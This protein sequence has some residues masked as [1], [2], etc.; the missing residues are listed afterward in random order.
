[1]GWAIS[2]RSGTLYYYGAGKAAQ[3]AAGALR[4]AVGGVAGAGADHAGIQRRVQYV[5]RRPGG[6]QPFERSPVVPGRR[7]QTDHSSFQ[8]GNRR[9][10]R[11]V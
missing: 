7:R 4:N 6:V 8:R 1:M 9:A 10:G 5:A 2:G 11:H 3:D